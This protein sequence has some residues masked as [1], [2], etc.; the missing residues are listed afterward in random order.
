MSYELARIL[1]QHLWCRLPAHLYRP[2]PYLCVFWLTWPCS[3]PIPP[4]LGIRLSDCRRRRRR[5][6]I[7][8]AAPSPLAGHLGRAHPSS[9][10]TT[11]SGDAA[12]G[13]PRPITATGIWWGVPTSPPSLPQVPPRRRRAFIHGVASPGR[14][15]T[16]IHAIQYPVLQI[17][18]SYSR[19]RCSYLQP[20]LRL[21]ILLLAGAGLVS[22][23]AAFG[24]GPIC[25]ATRL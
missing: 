24:G 15:R 6:G 17:T 23:T 8:A 2:A 1:M 9:L 4:T 12:C 16:L 19:R 20:P 13:R 11:R 21:P 7:S 14:N 3:P 25:G 10:C 22:S 18:S 5:L